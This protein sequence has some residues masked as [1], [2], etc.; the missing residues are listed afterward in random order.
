LTRCPYGDHVALNLYRCSYCHRRYCSFHSDPLQHGCRKFPPG[1]IY[2]KPPGKQW[3]DGADRGFKWLGFFLISWIL[4][5]VIIGSVSRSVGPSN[6]IILSLVDSSVLF[7]VT[8][9]LAGPRR[10]SVASKVFAIVIILL[11]VGVAYENES[12]FANL[13]PSS[14]GSFFSGQAS[15]LDTL[16]PGARSAAPVASSTTSA[17]SS[18]L[19]STQNTASVITTSV[20]TASSAT[21]PS[22]PTQGT[23]LS[24]PDFVNGV[25]D[26]T[27][28]SDYQTLADY[29]LSVINADR[30][31]YGAAPLTLGAI[32]SG[33]QHADSML[34]FNYFGH[35]DTQGYDPFTRFEMLGGGDSLMGENIGLDYCNN[36][37]ASATEISPVS[38]NTNTVENA[39]ANSE[40]G[41]VYN[42]AVCCNNGHREN[43]LDASYTQ[44]S[45]GIEYS[46]TNSIVYFVED[47]YGPCPAGYICG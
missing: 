34:Y 39:I 42:D 16:I 33:Q 36:S 21:T 2:G 43:I 12:Q 45:I 31:E 14:V 32:P 30:A 35:N 13:S 22:V 8:Y 28:P 37:P 24:N 3:G 27:Y 4:L 41:M 17:T 11:L 26:I 18:I 1:G 10:R 5:L 23:T 6:I 40:W 9:G 38:C 47:F 7:I 29:A 20:A 15:F 46:S 44:V 25:A 19:S